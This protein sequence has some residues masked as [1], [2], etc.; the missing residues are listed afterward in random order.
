M[1]KLNIRKH[2]SFIQQVF[3]N[4][5]KFLKES[6]FEPRKR[7]QHIAWP[8]ECM[9]QLGTMPVGEC[10][11]AMF[12]KILGVAQTEPMSLRGRNICD[13]GI[14]YE[15]QRIAKFKKLGVF[16]SEQVRIGYELPNTKNKV[17]ISGRM[18]C[19]IK[20]DGVKQG[21]EIKSVSAW[22]APA[23]MGDQRTTPLPAENNLMQAML[24]KYYLSEV[25]EGKALEIDDVYLMYVNRSDNS[26]F[27]YK[28]VLDAQGYAI[29]T[30]ID[31]AGKELYTLETQSVLSFD[32]LLARPGTNATSE[33][34][35]LASIR[36]S[37]YDI[38]SKFDLAYDYAV[39]E[40]LPPC[41]YTMIYNPNEIERE[42]K[43]G[44][45]S[46]V[47]HNKAKKGEPYGDKKCEYCS[48]KTKCMGDSGITLS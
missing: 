29:L 24:Y 27:Y 8:S 25:E 37:I 15:E 31:E 10:R 7:V 18:D 42:F 23:T 32:E 48:F 44:R 19:V 9:V 39:N 21:I 20:Y 11:R 4:D 6:E 38:F 28:I 47:K 22:K 3:K 40:M 16:D 17:V 46:K 35:R 30:A 34:A 33:E 14:M 5:L 45:M 13:A 12:Y 41:D 36:I 26:T 43:L 2:K 1:A